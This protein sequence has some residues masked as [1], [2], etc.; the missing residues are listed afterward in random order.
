MMRH[1]LCLVC[2]LCLVPMAMAAEPATPL[3]ALSQMPVTELTVFKDG[4][5]LVLHAGDMPVDEHGNVVMDYLPAPV[6]GTFWP[7][8]NDPNAKLVATVAGQRR[9][10]VKRTAMGLYELVLANIGA[11]V[12]ITESGLPQGPDTY[13]GTIERV[14]EMTAEQLE[15]TSPPNTGEKLP[16]RAQIVVVRTDKGR[17]IVPVERIASL[18]F[19]DDYET[20]VTSE[21]F[22]NLLTLKLDWGDRPRT[23]K[24]SV[25]LMYLQKGVRW[26]PNYKVDIDGNGTAA[27]TMQ[28]TLLNELV[29]L[30]DVTMNLVVGVPSFAFRDTTDPMALQQAI[31]QLSSYF[32]QGSQTRAGLSNAIMSQVA[33]RADE[34]ANRPNAEAPQPADLGPELAGTMKNEDLFVYTVR[35]ITLRKAERM[36]VPIGQFALPYRDVYSLDIPFAPPPEVMRSFNS[37]QLA[38]IAR[39][40][41]APKV[42]HSVR[43]TNKSEF[44]LTT[45]PAL[46]AANGR[47]LSQ[48]MMTYTPIGAD[49]DL[50]MTTAVDVRVTKTERETARVPNAVKWDGHDFARIDVEGTLR[51]T[52]H[53]AKPVEVEV[54]RHVLGQIKSASDG[55]QIRLI[56]TFEASDYLPTTDDASLDAR[57]IWWGWSSWP[58]WWHHF[59]GVGRVDWTMTIQPNE[60]AERT[61]TWQYIWQ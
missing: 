18:I 29:D 8:S 57:P 44:P 3:Q 49:G 20:Q 37:D 10:S 43:L 32:Q 5:A 30:R 2:L 1:I 61:Y 39:Q 55:G 12:T 16:V 31:A 7:F 53:S 13:T 48:G 15:Q 50:A 46:I 34:D 59:N 36:V 51:L 21:E 28:S 60:T 4:H 42:M 45:A 33:F 38:Q 40:A 58:Y 25:G 22:R 17:R 41:H 35:H 19:A 27:I 52:N 14:P 56:N 54:R 6:L 47:V 26:I 24:V 11:R 9:V 23:E